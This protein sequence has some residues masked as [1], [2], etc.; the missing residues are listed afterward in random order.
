VVY[1]CIGISDDDGCVIWP[2]LAC[3]TPTACGVIV[4][5]RSLVLA[6]QSAVGECSKLRVGNERDCET[7]SRNFP[8]SWEGYDMI[9][10][11]IDYIQRGRI[12]R[13]LAESLVYYYRT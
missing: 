5:I 13:R 10:Y 2:E 6:P 11:A 4:L 9:R 7:V 12:Y 3:G 1:R 8:E